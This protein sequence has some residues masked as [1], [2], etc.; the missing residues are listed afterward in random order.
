[1]GHFLLGDARRQ[2]FT[3]MRVLKGFETSRRRLRSLLAACFFDGD[4]G[5]YTKSALL[6]EAAPSEPWWRKAFALPLLNATL[7]ASCPSP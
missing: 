3:A 6:A 1:M 2:G 4:C 7:A 5:I